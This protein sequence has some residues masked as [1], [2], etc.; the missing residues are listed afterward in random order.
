MGEHI[1]EIL[2]I[3][4]REDSYTD[5]LKY[6]FTTSMEFRDNFLGLLNQESVGKWEIEVRLPVPIHSSFGRKR[7]IP[8]IVLINIEIRK[9]VIIEN[10]IFSGEGW[11][12]TNRYSSDEFKEGLSKHL[13]SEKCLEYE[14]FHFDYFYLTLDGQDASSGAFRKISYER[15][16]NKIPPNVQDEK[17][18]ILLD[19][20]KERINEIINWPRPNDEELVL[21][22]LK[23]TKRLVSQYHTFKCLSSEIIP[24]EP[25][26]EITANPGSGFIPLAQWQYI[27]WVSGNADSPERIIEPCFNIHFEFQ[28]DSRYDSLTLYLHY[29]TN[30]YMTGKKKR[31]LPSQFIEK[32]DELRDQ[33]FDRIKNKNPLKWTL[34]KRDLQL[35]YYSFPNAKSITVGNLKSSMIELEECMRHHVDEALSETR[36]LSH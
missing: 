14:D 3:S 5:L 33:F 20:L 21:D 22:Y 31:G 36:N 29:E 18:R 7:D 35:A 13:R 23:R 25:Q 9:V 32:Y 30:P 15:L 1:F 26:F 16:I 24:K 17:L 4:E 10:K 11:E 6:A 8:D 2:G 27:N 34:N 12:Q 28:W 19:E